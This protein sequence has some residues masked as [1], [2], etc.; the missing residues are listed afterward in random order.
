[1]GT[2][3]DWQIRA[4][5]RKGNLVVPFEEELLNPASLDVRL[6]DFLMVESIYSPELVRVDIADKTADDPFQLQP[7]EFVLAETREVFNFPDDLCAQFV[8][9]SSRGREGYNNVLAGF[10]DP[11]WHGSRLTME[12]KNE[13]L[14][15]PLPLFPGLKIGQLVFSEM[16][17]TPV[18]SYAITGRYNNDLTVTA[19]AA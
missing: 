7:G 11:G 19:S 5:C 13:R 8:L 1:M 6:G 14:H 4:R 15:H 2:L 18:N 16:A 12:L 17:Q 3:A 10:I 9:K